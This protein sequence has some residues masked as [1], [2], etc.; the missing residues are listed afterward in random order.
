MQAMAS[1]YVKFCSIST[2]SGYVETLVR[3]ILASANLL[4][5]TEQ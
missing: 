3:R 2:K 1:F 4:H 5:E